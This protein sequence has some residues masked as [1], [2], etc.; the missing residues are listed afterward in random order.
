MLISNVL[1]FIVS[2]FYSAHCGGH[3]SICT[4]GDRKKIKANKKESLLVGV[5]SI[6]LC[7]AY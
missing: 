6:V 4:T 7:G 5:F 1:L 3:K 2:T